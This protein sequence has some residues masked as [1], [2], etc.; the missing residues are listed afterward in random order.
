[1]EKKKRDRMNMLDK[2]KSI[3]PSLLSDIE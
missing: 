2:I 3:E 1:M